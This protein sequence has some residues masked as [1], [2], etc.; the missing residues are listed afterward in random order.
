MELQFQFGPSKTK[1]HFCTG[2]LE[3]SQ[4]IK[5]SVV[6]HSALVFWD[7]GLGKVW[8]QNLIGAG[9]PAQQIHEIPG[10]E[11]AKEWNA[12]GKNIEFLAGRAHERPAP[13]VV[14][15]GGALCDASALVASLYRRGIPLILVPTTLL[16]M[17]DAAVGGKTAVDLQADGK[18]LKNVAGNFY[19]AQSVYF[20]PDW[21]D[22]LPLA[23]KRSGLG[24][25]FKMLWLDGHPV[26]P[27]SY[28][29]WLAGKSS[30][31]EHWQDLQRAVQV[32]VRVVEADPLD[33]LGIRQQLNYG[34]TVGHALEALGKGSLSHGEAVAWGMWAES[35]FFNQNSSFSEQILAVLQSLE[36]D[37]PE[38]FSNLNPGQLAACMRA[39]KKM[40]GSRLSMSVLTEPGKLIHEAVAPHDLANKTAKL[41]N[42]I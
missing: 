39:D 38:F 9:I 40:Q 3:W 5:K 16:G 1:L 41:F 8:K 11:Q 31:S 19:P 22:T 13:L 2:Q 33:D 34:H 37:R 29:S 28:L 15:G 32:K 20:W 4:S 25:L 14:I 10:G 18:L 24:E 26:E 23:E 6:Q 7:Q 27:R 35:Y 17:V 21:L 12:V 30:F 36:F 42:Q